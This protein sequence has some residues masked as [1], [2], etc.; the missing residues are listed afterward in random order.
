MEGR[1]VSEGGD[2]M[3]KSPT[4]EGDYFFGRKNYWRGEDCMS[5]LLIFLV[6]GVWFWGF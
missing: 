6:L 3:G 4:G 2:M 5:G 1:R